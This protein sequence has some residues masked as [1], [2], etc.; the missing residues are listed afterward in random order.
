MKEKYVVKTDKGFSEPMSREAAISK[1]KTY[2]NEGVNAYIVSEDEGE[3]IKKSNWNP[4]T[5]S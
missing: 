5:W 3:R 2:S 1:V 4:P